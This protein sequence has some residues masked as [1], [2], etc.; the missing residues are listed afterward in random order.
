MEKENFNKKYIVDLLRFHNKLT[1]SE[2]SKLT[3]LSR[4]TIYLHL[5]SL[6]KNGFIKRKKD[7]D[8]KGAPVSIELIKHSVAQKD[9]KELIDFLKLIKEH[10][11]ITQTELRNLKVPITSSLTIATFDGLI[12]KKIYIT[13]K[14]IKFLEDNK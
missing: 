4:P 10:N 5:D 14:G 3:K 7:E 11:G 8:K 1:I 13:E 12:D 6:E 9:K 2:I